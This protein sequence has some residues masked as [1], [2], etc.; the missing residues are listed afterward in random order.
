[1]EIH[2]PVT[3][4]MLAQPHGYAGSAGFL[5]T[6]DLN[7]DSKQDLVEA[8]SGITVLIGNGD[9]T[10]T[11]SAS[12]AIPAQ[13]VGLSF[14][15]F[16]NDG[17]LDFVV[18]VNEKGDAVVAL[19]DGT[20]KFR[21]LPAFGRFSSPIQ[22]VVGDFNRDG[23]LDLIVASQSPFVGAGPEILLGNGDGTFQP[24]QTITSIFSPYDLTSADFNGDGIL[25][26]ALVDG[27]TG[28]IAV[29]LGNGDG[30][31]Q[32]LIETQQGDYV[33][34]LVGDFNGDGKL[35]FAIVGSGSPAPIGVLLGN[36]DGTLQSPQF[37][38]TGF[39]G[40]APFFALG[41]FNS[42]G[43]TDFFSYGENGFLAGFLAGN[44]DGT[45]QRVSRLTMPG[46]VFK[47]L[48]V[49]GDFNSDGLLDMATIVHGGA[50]VY[51]QAPQ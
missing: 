6:A 10:F 12:L 47:L 30:T 39:I 21:Q 36:G 19:G 44:G 37:Y 33:Q 40:Q 45:F 32:P 20:G 3:N 49:V 25:D 5:F 42:D 7:G 4:I 46:P 41:D 11:R 43:S 1:V 51:L 31:F 28:L 16:N 24:Q 35:D 26:L 22:T 34:T 18:V 13:P 15:D 17:K 9:G 23:N 38:S 48:P 14:G 2:E 29:L 8:G 27:G 50:D